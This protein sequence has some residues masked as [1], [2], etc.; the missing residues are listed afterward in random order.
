MIKYKAFAHTILKKGVILKEF[1]KLCF[2]RSAVIIMKCLYYMERIKDDE[3][4]NS[5]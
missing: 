2:C 3:Y 5:L 1:I 4:G